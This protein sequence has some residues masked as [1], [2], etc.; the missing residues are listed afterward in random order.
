[1][2][3]PIPISA[4]ET[5]PI[6]PLQQ[7]QAWREI[8]QPMFD[9]APL[10]GREPP[11]FVGEFESYLLGPLVL[12]GTTFDA[13]RYGR[14]PARIRRDG[15]NHYQVQLHLSGGYIGR[16]DERDLTLGVGDMVLFDFGRPLD[17]RS[18]RSDLLV[19]AVPRDILELSMAPGDHHGLVLRGDTGLGGL[20]ADHMRSLAARLP[21]MATD[22]AT[23]AA[24]AT[25]AMIA[26][27]FRPSRASFAHA[28]P[29]LL[30]ALGHRIRTY[31]E[32]NLRG[33]PIAVD[34]LCRTFSLS[35]AS[36]Y[37]I[38]VPFGGVAAYVRNQ[39]LSHA[40]TSL[41]TPVN[42]HRRIGEIAFDW[43]FRGEAHFSRA[44]REAFG[45]TPSEARATTPDQADR[46][47]VAY[48]DWVA[49]LRRT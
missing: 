34:G 3:R 10:D 25:T 44:F 37:R 9:A 26:A 14:D 29:A 49:R 23:A 8:L 27:C 46:V 43:G 40:F 11:A 16:F 33:G 41:M 24:T 36:L 1:V 48:R 18:Q 45:L 7:F 4:F 13:H 28:Q 31:I 30:E 35:R 20:M 19:I 15:L 38:F 5:A 2:S 47:N 22:E 39:R 32:Q 12:G 17:A 21:L 6:A 42:N